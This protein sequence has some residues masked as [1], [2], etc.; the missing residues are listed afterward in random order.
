MDVKN[1]MDFINAVATNKKIVCPNCET[2]NDPD[3]LFCYICGTS[4]KQEKKT[5][6]SD[7]QSAFKQAE[8]KPMPE[9]KQQDSFKT[10]KDEKEK[11]SEKQQSVQ[12]NMDIFAKGLPQW[13]IIP[14]ATMV[15]R[16]SK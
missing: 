3:A 10:I 7:E 6:H 2:L 4:L 5:D 12:Q 15:R 14:P 8:P 16:K 1:K 11:V 13:D 9:K